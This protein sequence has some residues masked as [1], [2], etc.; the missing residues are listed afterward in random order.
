M[1]IV[2]KDSSITAVE[3]FGHSHVV[4]LKYTKAKEVAEMLKQAFGNRIASGDSTPSQNQRP[5]EAAGGVR[6]SSEVERRDGNEAAARDVAE[7]PTRGRVPEMTIAAHQPSNTLIVTAP[8]ALFEEVRTVID[9]IDLMSEQVVEVIPASG[10]IDVEAILRRLNGEKFERPA[11]TSHRQLRVAHR[12]ALVDV[13]AD[14]TVIPFGCKDY[15]TS[16]FLL[17]DGIAM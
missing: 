14:E 2:D 10:G 13:V 4:E 12:Q 3:T 5:G 9:S 1:K 11:T 8:D 7:K 17:V 15:C 16:D 6:P